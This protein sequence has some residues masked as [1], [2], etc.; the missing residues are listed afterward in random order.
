MN[1]IL[2]SQIEL[3]P[4]KPG[5]YLM[6]DKNDV[7]IYIGKAKNLKNRVS[8]YFLRSQNGKTAAMVS[9]VDH[10]ETI[11]TKSEKEALI[12]EMN[13][14][15]THHPRYNIMLMDDKHYPYIAIHKEVKDPYVS[16]SRNIKNKKCEYFG[17]Y[18]NSK[19][20]YEIVNM[21]NKLFPLRKCNTVPKSACLYFHMGRCLAPCINDVKKEEYQKII[22]DIDTFLKGNNTKII[23][24]I[25]EKIY[26]ASEQLDFESAQEYKKMLDYIEHISE[27]Q[28]VEFKDNINRDIFAF[29]IR[30]GYVSLA[31][32]IYRNGILLAKRSFCYSLIGEINE[33]VSSLI[34]QYYQVNTVPKEIIV[35]NKEIEE[36]LLGSLDAT[37]LFPT[38]GKLHDVISVVEIN[39]KEALDAHFLTAR[40]DDDKFALLEKL[41]KILNIKTPIRIELF[42][43][44]HLQ[45]TNAIGA[46]VVFINGEPYKKMYRKFNIES[47]NK[48]DDL[49]SM[50]ESLTRRYSRLK[51]EGEQFPDLVIVDG[52]TTQLEVAKEVMKGL[53][54]KIPL[55]GL[56]KSDKHRT[57]ALM[58]EKFNEYNL[59]EDKELFFLLT[60]MQ[61]EVHRYAINTHIKKRNKNMFAS[62]FDDIKGIGIKRKEELTKTYPS[63]KELKNASLE[64]LKQ[65]LPEESAVALYNKL[66]EI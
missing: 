3:L 4:N 6:H 10:F 27:K 30:E 34:Y 16:L 65:L 45:G 37:V 63:I 66:K 12:L 40:L 17:P 52:G 11:I 19:A 9:H 18:P 48:K 26:K 43:N 25:K 13:L 56:V 23:G 54:L 53:D 32:F 42:D 50:K 55:A 41:G 58:D 20:A 8:Q 33:F 59:T 14:I 31:C 2:K 47:I 61:D 29:Y 64:E 1:D 39:A 28:I 5:C 24:S 22:D 62:V 46:M 51:N 36:T 49:S 44:S 21:I 15:Q 7:I 57:S 38:K 60:R 35:S